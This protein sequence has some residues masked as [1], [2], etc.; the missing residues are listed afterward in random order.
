V[1]PL[2]VLRVLREE[3]VLRPLR[4]DGVL[5]EPV[6][7]EPLP[8]GAVPVPAG[9]AAP[10]VPVALVALGDTAAARGAAAIPHT[11]Q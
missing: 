8:R 3:R 6:R 1:R 5:P 9:P 10:E 7:A 11:L 2:R 4:V